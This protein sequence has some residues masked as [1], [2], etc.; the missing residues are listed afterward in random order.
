MLEASQKGIS[1]HT[2]LLKALIANQDEAASKEH[3]NGMEGLVSEALK[4]MI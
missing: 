3:C 2:D 4:H 1:G